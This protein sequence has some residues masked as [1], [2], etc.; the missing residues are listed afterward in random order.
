VKLFLIIVYF[1]GWTAIPHLLLLK[2]RP[3]ATLAWLWAIL[4]IPYLG[5][6]AYFAIGT[7]RLTRKR[8]KRRN[9]FSVRTHRQQPLSTD[10]STGQLIQQLAG[11]Q[12]DFFRLLSSIHR[13]P[14]TSA[15]TIR[16]FGDGTTFYPALEERINRARHHVHLEFYILESDERG[17]K[18]MAALTA[19][20]RR[21][22]EVRLLID[23]MGSRE[24][25]ESVLNAFLAAGGRFSWFQSLDAR[26]IRFFFNLRNHRKLQI[27][28][29][30]VA[31]VGGMNVGCDYEGLNPALGKWRDA[32]VE[33]TGPV[34]SELQMVFADD[35]YFATDEKISASVY[36]PVYAGPTRYPVHLVMGG[37]DSRREPISKSFVSLLNL[38]S[39][40]AWIATGY[41]VPDDTLLNALELAAARGVDVRLI[42]SEKTDHPHLVTVGRSYYD[43]L[44][45]MGVR[46]FEYSAGVNHAK[47]ALVDDHWG[48]IGSAN[49]DYRSMRLNFELNLI[50][51]SS[52]QTA[53]LAQILEEDFAQCQELDLQVFRR[54]RFRTQF[55]EAALRPLSP[56]L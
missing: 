35:W 45:S 6:V 23:E 21:G 15:E 10:S 3:Q 14:I 55:L 54:R 33:V 47:I 26:R 5:A 1:T 11:P 16:I 44:L 20:V 17:E 43:Q 50:F 25:D 42:I 7:D 19:A 18:L 22:V 30:E 9:Q 41:F 46:I 8:L 32:Q 12:R 13:M 2:K 36:Y 40:R 29:G 49:L 24:M 56:L 28:D 34:T 48:M 53:K 52:E 38:A 51:H 4:F 39:R 37:P 27:I 31:F